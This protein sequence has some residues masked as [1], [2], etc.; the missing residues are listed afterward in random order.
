MVGRTGVKLILF[1]LST[2][3]SC[4]A[5]GR[6]T[7]LEESS[8][9]GL[10]YLVALILVIAPEDVL[11]LIQKALITV[12]VLDRMSFVLIKVAIRSGNE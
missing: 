6:A 12:L 11:V 9:E 5:F 8:L 4:L 10:P 7:L 1:L 3:L 2:S